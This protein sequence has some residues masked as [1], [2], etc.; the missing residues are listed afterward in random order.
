MTERVSPPSPSYSNYPKAFAIGG[1][2]CCIGEAFARL[3]IAA[4]LG[5]DTA[6]SLS[7][8]TLVFIAAVLTAL[9]WFAPIAKHAGAG[10]LVPITGFANSIVSPAIE[11][12]SEGMVFG[13]G[14]KMFVI[15]GPVLVFGITASAIYGLILWIAGLF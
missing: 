10:T 8:V 7:S 1:L 2:I 11:F 14:A 15:A 9:G 6:R 13:M 12:K 5:E 3:Y 4:G